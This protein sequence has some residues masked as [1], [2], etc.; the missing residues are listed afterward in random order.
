MK[1]LDQNNVYNVYID[2]YLLPRSFL[3]FIEWVIWVL[4]CLYPLYSFQVVVHKVAF[5]YMIM[6]L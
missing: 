1:F 5:P 2:R 4:V 3:T 6:Y